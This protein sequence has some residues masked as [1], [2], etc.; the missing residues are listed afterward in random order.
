MSP[1]CN[2]GRYAIR[3][4]TAS[5]YIVL[6]TELDRSTELFLADK[7]HVLRTMLRERPDDEDGLREEIE[8]ESEARRYQQ[9]Y[10]RL[11]DEHGVPIM[12]TP[13]MDEQLDLAELASRTRGRSERSI[14]MAGRHGQPLR[15][16]SATVTVGTLPTHSDT[17][18]IAI[19]VS[20]EVELLARYRMWFWGIL[21][22]TSILFPL[23]GYRIARHGIR[24]VE[25]I[26]ATARRI[27]STNLRERIGSEGY[28]SELASLAGTFNEMLERLEES[29]ERISRFTADI[30]HDLRTPVNNIR[31]EAEVAL[32]RARTVDEYRDVLESSLEEAVRLSELIGDLL[33]LARAESPL[34]ELHRE[35][36]N[37]SELLTTVRD[38]YEASATDAGISFVVKEWA[39]PLNAELDR[40]LMLRA[41]SNLVSNAIA[42]TL[43]G[44]TVTL[45]ATNED[46]VIRIEIS[47]TGVGIPAEAIPSVFDRFFR[48][49]P[50]RSKISGS[51]GLGL[52]IVQSIL[53]LHGG[54]AEITNQLGHGTRVTLRM[55]VLAMR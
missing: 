44:G 41:V 7:L 31:G 16:T 36:M 55:P 38:Y 9:F 26:A 50:S 21:L 20:Q 6:R 30:A 35:N 39:H 23:V 34:T 17:V 54:S 51:T 42:H 11:L 8:L 14:A 24:P 28:P 22:A 27:T 5:L 46:A 4:I 40:S 32:A 52:A 2:N 45:A 10:I 15:V 12:T 48:V 37:I 49:D 47:D 19:D 29:F 25:E 3:W 1:G 43:P 18:Q 13:G 53:A 33:F